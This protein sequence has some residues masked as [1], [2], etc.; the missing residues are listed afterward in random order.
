[1][2]NYDSNPLHAYPP[3]QP[4]NGV[5]K[6]TLLLIGI[7]VALFVLQ[8]LSGVDFSDPSTRD[9][10]HWGADYAP[11]TYLSEPYRLF[12]SMFFHF[13]FMHLLMNMWALFVFGNIAEQVFGRA[14]YLGLYIL[15]GLMGNLLSGYLDILNSYAYLQHPAQDLIPRVSAG[16]SGAVMG[17][18]GALT[19][20]SFFRN[21]PYLDRKS[22][23][24]IMIANV[25]F[26]FFA[27]GINNMAHIGGIIMGVILALGWH[28]T[29][30]M[31][32]GKIM[33]MIVLGLGIALCF[34]FYQYNQQQIQGLLALWQDAANQ[35]KTMLIN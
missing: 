26:G 31:Y 25:G 33:P 20:L 28:F 30:K 14:Y 18:G 10:M 13:G 27:S 1:M 3:N 21:V 7:N 4:R 17:L 32:A 29:Q 11:L 16:A 8:V 12:S 19:A 35:M 6:L 24:I 22:L 23:L 34:V 5:G 2:S 9:A 15:A